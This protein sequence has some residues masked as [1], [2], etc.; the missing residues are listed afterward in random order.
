MAIFKITDKNKEYI[1]DWKKLANGVS[2]QIKIKCL[3]G[4]SIA[5]YVSNMH[6]DKY[7]DADITKNTGFALKAG[8]EEVISIGN[9]AGN[10]QGPDKIYI[11]GYNVVP[12]GDGST[13]NN[14]VCSIHVISINT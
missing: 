10:A 5:C 9:S 12:Y 4:N 11:K 8:E 2:A 14:A 3:S 7:P 6:P 13:F 1:F